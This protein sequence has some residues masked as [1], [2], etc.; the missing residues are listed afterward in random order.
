MNNNRAI[1]AMN[2]NRAINAMNSN[3]LPLKTSVDNTS[4]TNI[5]QKL[6]FWEKKLWKNETSFKEIKTQFE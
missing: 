4:M 2:N 3:R 1:N 5:G 6:L